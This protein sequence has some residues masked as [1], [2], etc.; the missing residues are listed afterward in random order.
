MSS[1]NI[2]SKCRPSVSCNS[3][4]NT[5]MPWGRDSNWSVSTIR[6]LPLSHHHTCHTSNFAAS[7]D[8]VN[9]TQKCAFVENLFPRV[10]LIWQHNA[11]GWVCAWSNYNTLL[12]T[13]SIVAGSCF[14]HWVCLND[15]TCL[16][17]WSNVSNMVSESP[18]NSAKLPVKCR[19]FYRYCIPRI[20]WL[21]FV[22]NE[23]FLELLVVL[24][25]SCPLSVCHTF[26][27]SYRSRLV[28][29]LLYHKYQQ[30]LKYNNNIY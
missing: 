11:E 12:W 13:Q 21:P 3:L 19:L 26:S 25:L 27:C 4:N 16:Q 8:A 14:L 24:W 2:Y 6:P 20:K 18:P 5:D 15:V 9:I 7:H 22:E 23:K 1:S 28:W 29:R 17:T 10:M 30:T